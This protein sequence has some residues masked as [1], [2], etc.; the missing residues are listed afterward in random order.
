MLSLPLVFLAT[1]CQ[2]LTEGYSTDPLNVTDPSIITTD[3]FLS[4][5][6][7][8]L[9]GAYEGDINRLT[10]MWIGYFSGDDRQYV[11]LA[12]YSVSGR[13]FNTEWSAIYSGVLKNTY[14]IKG[15]ARIENNPLLLGIAQTMEAMAVGLAAD[16]WGDVP[17]SEAI[18]YPE[19]STP[20]YDAQAD[21]YARLQLM[22]DSAVVNFGKPLFSPKQNPGGAD[23]FFS[24]DAAAWTAVANTL[25]AR[26]F[27]H[28]KNYANAVTYSNMG[29]NDPAGNMMA[30][31]GNTYQQN[32]NLFYSFGVYDRPGYMAATSAYAPQ[33]LQSR[34]DGVTDETARFNYYYVG[35]D[36][37]Y[38][39]NYESTDY[40]GE[41]WDTSYNG[42]FGSDTNFPL[43]TY[44]ENLLIRAEASMKAN[45]NRSDALAALND[46]RAY[47]ATG[48]G[49]AAGYASDD[50]PIY[51]LYADIDFATN[52]DLLK[53]ILTERYLTFIGQLEGFID[54]ARTN[55]YLGLPVIG[56]N[57][58]VPKRLLYPQ[59]EINTNAK[60]IPSNNVGLFDPLPV[61][62]T[63]Y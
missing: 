59:S 9:I 12:N 31:H 30:P 20:K 45:N 4:G 44:E 41:G 29:I 10:G 61:F 35:G 5:A 49:I 24:G 55:N 11:P 3:K 58:S 50:A 18:R 51:D 28:A 46:L 52:A 62:S 8:N 42:F 56:G 19:I 57:A 37:A 32:F 1:G 13:D 6:Q 33:L 2:N 38:D 39:L 36:G 60:S 16:L 23:I 25:K 27:L 34:V 7:V 54:V 15:R 47:R 14:I 53:E 48:G 40:E 21:V 17:Y 43:V 22:L 26:Y 63:P